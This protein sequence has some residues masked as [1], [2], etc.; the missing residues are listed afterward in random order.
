MPSEQSLHGE[1]IAS[2][3]PL[4]EVSD[5]ISPCVAVATAATA[6]AADCGRINA[7]SM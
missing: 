5:E 4:N 7:L 3:D 6:V 1:L 2:G